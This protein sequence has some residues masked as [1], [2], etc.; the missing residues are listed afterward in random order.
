MK[1]NLNTFLISITLVQTSIILYNLYNFNEELLLYTLNNLKK[2]NFKNFN[3]KLKK[4][5]KKIKKF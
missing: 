3:K 1:I 2:K 5:N 4:F